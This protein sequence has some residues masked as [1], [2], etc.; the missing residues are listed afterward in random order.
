MVDQY[1][2]QLSFAK[3][4][5]T[6]L[7]ASVKKNY[8]E[9]KVFARPNGIDRHPK[10]SDALKEMMCPQIECKGTKMF[11]WRCVLGRC[12]RCPGLKKHNLESSKIADS[13]DMVA[14]EH[15]VQF[16]RCTKH[17][18]LGKGVVKECSSCRELGMKAKLSHK[19]KRTKDK[20]GIEDFMIDF[21]ETVLENTNSIMFT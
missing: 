14:F 2:L 9:Y 11:H 3:K 12:N 4:L 8:E 7:V 6:R 17:G 13:N 21:Y 10:A 19:K 15:Y 16:S 5:Q 20:K 1:S 18:L